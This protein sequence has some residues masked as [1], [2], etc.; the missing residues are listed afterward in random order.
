M[1]GLRTA[2][3]RRHLAVRSNTELTF[4]TPTVRCSR[5][6]SDRAGS[7]RNYNILFDF[8]LR[9]VHVRH[10]GDSPKGLHT[11]PARILL[12]RL[13]LRRRH[14]LLVQVL[15]FGSLQGQ[16]RRAP[17]R[18]SALQ[19]YMRFWHEEQMAR[20][21]VYRGG[22]PDFKKLGQNC[23]KNFALAGR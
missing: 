18:A 23:Q 5:S 19:P 17:K 11:R 16:A 21:R 22:R 2:A 20:P 9:L 1:V 7:N 13:H 6:H 12:L 10:A 3:R 8:I 14:D 4:F 15:A